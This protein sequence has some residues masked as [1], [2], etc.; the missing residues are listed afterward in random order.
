MTLSDKESM[1][2]SYWWW[3]YLTKKQRNKELIEHLKKQSK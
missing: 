1:V 3:L 2:F